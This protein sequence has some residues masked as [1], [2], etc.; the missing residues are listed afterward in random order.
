MYTC[1]LFHDAFQNN[2]N[3]ITNTI[4]GTLFGIKLITSITLDIFPFCLTTI[5]AT[6]VP[7]SEHIVAVKSAIIKLFVNA[8]IPVEPKESTA[9]K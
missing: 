3:P 1:S 5:I 9:L 7:I 8:L 2:I 6:I 4:A